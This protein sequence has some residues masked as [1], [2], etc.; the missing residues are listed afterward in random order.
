MK[1]KLIQNNFLDTVKL[2]NK[3]RLNKENLA[4]ITL[5]SGPNRGKP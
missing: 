2:G 1:K 5:F 3:E 4:I